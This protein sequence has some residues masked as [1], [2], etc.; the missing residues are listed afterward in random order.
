MDIFLL[1]HVNGLLDGQG[2][3]KL[4]GVY[5]STDLADQARGRF[6]ELPGFRDQPAGF[7][8]SRCTLNRDTNWLEGYV[9]VTHAD[10]RRDWRAGMRVEPATPADYV[11]THDLTRRNMGGYVARHWGAWDP[12]IYL[13]NYRTTENFVLWLDGR[14]VG[15]VRLRPDADALVL[16]DLQVP[17]EYQNRGIGTDA[18]AAVERMARSRGLRAVRLRC[19]HDNPARR[20]YLR[21]GY[22]VTGTEA[23]ADW[24]EKRV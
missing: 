16:D 6:A 3:A 10:T 24:M 18:L 22:A 1:W 13:R 9:T 12:D 8:V 4:L 11:F 14:R 21:I 20:L 5:S 7:Q 17:P 23:G 19:F 2:D 15:F